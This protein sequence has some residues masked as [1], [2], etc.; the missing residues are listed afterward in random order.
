MLVS[1]R[2]IKRPWQHSKKQVQWQLE[3]M[4]VNIVKHLWAEWLLVSKVLLQW[5]QMQVLEVVSNDQ[6]C[7]Q[8]QPQLV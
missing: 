8:F 5:R 2:K 7:F 4:L 1:K 3:L 6:I